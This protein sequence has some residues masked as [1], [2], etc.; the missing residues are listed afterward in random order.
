M[1]PDHNIRCPNS[2]YSHWFCQFSGQ[3]LLYI[4]METWLFSLQLSDVS[5]DGVGQCTS[6]TSC[7]W[8]FHIG[9]IT[10]LSSVVSTGELEMSSLDRL[11][12]V[13]NAAAR[14][15]ARSNRPVLRSALHV[16]SNWNVYSIAFWGACISVWVTSTILFSLSSQVKYAHFP[17]RPTHLP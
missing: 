7:Q 9:N 15:L 17:V 3:H 2:Y 6:L 12:A 1:A 5:A 14:P 8:I 13:Q 16:G 10:K 4:W 11:Q